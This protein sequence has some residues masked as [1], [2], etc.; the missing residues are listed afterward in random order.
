MTNH[1]LIRCTS[2]AISCATRVEFSFQ[3]FQLGQLVQLFHPYS[4][5]R[6]SFFFQTGLAKSV[7]DNASLLDS[8][9]FLASVKL[10]YQR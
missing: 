10:L 7:V 8:M 3:D 1:L 4:R 5:F 9:T 2:I 6:E